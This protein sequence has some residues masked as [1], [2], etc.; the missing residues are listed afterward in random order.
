MHLSSVNI[1]QIAQLD[2]ILLPFFWDLNR[3]LKEHSLVIYYTMRKCSFWNTLERDSHVYTVYLKYDVI[4]YQSFIFRWAS[5]VETSRHTQQDVVKDVCWQWYNVRRCKGQTNLLSSQ[6]YSLKPD[7]AKCNP[8][9][10]VSDGFVVLTRERMQNIWKPHTDTE[11]HMKKKNQTQA[12]PTNLIIMCGLFRRHQS[13][14][15]PFLD[16]V[17]TWWWA[18]KTQPLLKKL[19]CRSLKDS[20]IWFKLT[21][22]LHAPTLSVCNSTSFSIPNTCGAVLLLFLFGSALQEQL[23]IRG[24]LSPVCTDGKRGSVKHDL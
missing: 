17:G 22:V 11:R 3:Y 1:K 14:P 16:T 20:W 4:L 21:V 6:N 12:S 10:V 7:R 13:P 8:S 9:V 5:T 15:L 24:C 2:F 23:M 19:R 18:W